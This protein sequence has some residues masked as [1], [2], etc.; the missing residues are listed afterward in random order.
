MKRERNLVR[1]GGSLRRIERRPLLD[2][3]RAALSLRFFLR[4]ANEYC[5]R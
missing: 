1:V 3:I 4:F 5:C 2:E